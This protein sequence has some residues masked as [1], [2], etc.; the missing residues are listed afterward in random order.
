[1][2]ALAVRRGECGPVGGKRKRVGD[3]LVGAAVLG[4]GS[5]WARAEGWAREKGKGESDGPESGVSWV[6]GF[7]FFISLSLLFL[8]QTSLNSNKDLNSNHT[9]LKVCTSMNAQQ[10]FKLRQILITLGTKI[11]L[12]ASLAQ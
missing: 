10:I 7:A 9:Q 5:C 3:R 2:R 11:K 12:N 8:I 1:V 6:L 4:R